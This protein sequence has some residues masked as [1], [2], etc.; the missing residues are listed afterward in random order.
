MIAGQGTACFEAVKDAGIPDAVF[1]ACGGGGLL[2]GTWLATQALCPQV[3]VWGAEPKQGNDAAQSLAKGEIV[4][5]TNSPETVA[6]AAATLSISERTFAYLR[7]IAGIIEVEEEAMLYWAQWLSHLLKTPVEP[8]SAAPMQAAC[9]WLST[10]KTPQTVL[11]ILSGANIAPEMYRRIWAKDYL[12]QIPLA[13]NGLK[14]RLSLTST[15][16]K[17]YTHAMLRKIRH[18]LEGALICFALLFFRLLPLDVASSFMGTLARVFGP[19]SRAHRTARANLEMAMPELSD[20]QRSRILS[21]MWDN[22]G[23][24]I[25][26]YPHLSRPIMAKRITVE[27]REHLE[28]LRAVGQT[29]VFVSG[30]FANWEILPLTASLCGSPLV[31]IYR[32]ANNPVAEWL[33]RRIRAPYTLGMYGKGRMGA[34]QSIK[35]LK[36]GRPL[37]MLIDQ[38]QNDGSPLPF[39]GRTAMTT[40]AATQLAIKYQVP[41]LAARVVRHSR[42]AFPCHAGT[43]GLF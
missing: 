42:R 9:D 1:A 13:G 16:L 22:M 10:K 11:I 28:K 4:A 35:A 20:L 29:M 31:V 8:T 3:P 5:F 23:R 30:H 12:S 18:A 7:R 24:V 38:K 25:G 27:G 33:I 14:S 15:R 26:E 6:D 19:F 17:H 32:E 41:L 40:T 34:V 43:P 37:A 21:G 39:F 2:S 36:E